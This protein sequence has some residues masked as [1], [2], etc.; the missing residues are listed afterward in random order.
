M[1]QLGCFIGWNHKR[2]MVG[3][4]LKLELENVRVLHW[5]NI[6]WLLHVRLLSVLSGKAPVRH[7]LDTLRYWNYLCFFFER[8]HA[9]HHNNRRKTRTYW[10]LWVKR[11]HWLDTYMYMTLTFQTLCTCQSLSLSFDTL[12]VLVFYWAERVRHWD[13]LVLVGWTLVSHLD[14]LVFTGS[15]PFISRIVFS[16]SIKCTTETHG[17]WLLN[18]H[19]FTFMNMWQL[20]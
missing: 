13:W 18:T 15:T 12:N 7:W 20:L 17:I 11:V 4:L 19:L 3:D 8:T 16:H 9:K 2:H 6:W 14:R 10:T 1:L 5:V